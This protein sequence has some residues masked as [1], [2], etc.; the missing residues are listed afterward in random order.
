MSLYIVRLLDS[1]VSAVFNSSVSKYPL[2]KEVTSHSLC[3][4]YT[5]VVSSFRISPNS[6]MHFIGVCVFVLVSV[7]TSQAHDGTASIPSVVADAESLASSYTSAIPKRQYDSASISSV[8]SSAE[9][10]L[11][12]LPSNARSYASSVAKNEIPATRSQVSSIWPTSRSRHRQ[13]LAHHRKMMHHNHQ[14]LN[15]ASLVVISSTAQDSAPVTSVTSVAPS[16]ALLESDTT[17]SAASTTASLVSTVTSA[18]AA[19]TAVALEV[20][21]FAGAVFLGLAAWL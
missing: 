4:Q 20:K 6:T 3:Y 16:A 11:S 18:A 14:H 21:G 2:S 15:T 7:T 1:T 19:A 12:S 9:S 8:I 17:S 13:L 5:T 10:R